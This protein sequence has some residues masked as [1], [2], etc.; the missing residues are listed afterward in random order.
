M[1]IAP[2]SQEFKL[3]HHSGFTVEKLKVR[4]PTTGISDVGVLSVVSKI[5]Q[6]SGLRFLQEAQSA[7]SYQQHF[8]EISEMAGWLLTTLIV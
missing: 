6:S 2:A 5:V 4:V 7:A 1:Q 8:T 3:L